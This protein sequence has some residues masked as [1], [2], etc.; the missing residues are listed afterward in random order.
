MK[1]NEL[2]LQ[3]AREIIGF[4]FNSPKKQQLKHARG[5]LQTKLDIIY[6]INK[7]V[8]LDKLKLLLLNPN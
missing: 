4:I 5:M 8:E 2:Q 1:N 7:L 3:G 6:I